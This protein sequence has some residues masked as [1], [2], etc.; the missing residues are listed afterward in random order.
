[1]SEYIHDPQATLDYTFDW[2]TLGWLADGETIATAT[3]TAQ[4]GLTIDSQTTG[5]EAVTVW[6]ST[7]GTLGDRTLACRITTSAGRTD[8]RTINLDVRNR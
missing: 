5:S 2:S 8:E 7:D 1:M 6:I 4:T 3:V